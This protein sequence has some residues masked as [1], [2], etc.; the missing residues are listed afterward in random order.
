MRLKK[1]EKFL[2]IITIIAISIALPLYNVKRNLDNSSKHNVI[3]NKDALKIFSKFDYNLNEQRYYQVKDY[4]ESIKKLRE[5]K[6]LDWFEEIYSD[7]DLN[8]NFSIFIGEY[9]KTK[10]NELN[11]KLDVL[12]GL[13][14]EDITKKKETNEF[15]YEN[16]IKNKQTIIEAIKVKIA[17]SVSTSRQLISYNEQLSAL[18]NEID[19]LNTEKILNENEINNNLIFI[20]I[21]HND[22]GDRSKIGLVKDFV[23][24][25]IVML[26]L[27]MISFIILSYI[28]RGISAL[29][30]ML[31]I[32][33]ERR[34]TRYN[35]YNSYSRGSKTTRKYMNDEGSEQK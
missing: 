25:F 21:Q 15:V 14:K 26:F 3:N 12:S 19:N 8:R 10:K 18:Q 28:Y 23:T 4:K 31:G 1:R 5:I 32:K 33:A 6:S 13:S 22:F 24:Q 34:S 16:H 2:I 7:I 29:M 20:Q 9:P 11:K 35:N 27:S 30:S 17:K